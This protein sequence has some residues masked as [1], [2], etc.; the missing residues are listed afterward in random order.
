MRVAASLG[1]SAASRSSIARKHGL[2]SRSQERG[3]LPCFGM[4]PAPHRRFQG[5]ERSDL[6]AAGARPLFG[7]PRA[8]GA[9]VDQQYRMDPPATAVDLAPVLGGRH[10]LTVLP[11]EEVLVERGEEADQAPGSPGLLRSKGPTG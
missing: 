7:A 6:Q 11:A 2:D 1:A 10:Q 4:D 8:H 5:G 3:Q 9:A